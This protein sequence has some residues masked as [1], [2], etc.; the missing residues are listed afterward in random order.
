MLYE[1]KLKKY[2]Q[3]SID[4][5]YRNLKDRRPILITKVW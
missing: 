4:T 1:M 3:T 5:Y 2:F